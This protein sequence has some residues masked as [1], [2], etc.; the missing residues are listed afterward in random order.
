M[1]ELHVLSV[2]IIFD[3][4]KEIEGDRDFSTHSGDTSVVDAIKSHLEE[5]YNIHLTKKD[6]EEEIDSSDLDTE[7]VF[8]MSTGNGIK[9]EFY[10][11]VLNGHKMKLKQ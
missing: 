11:K 6:I 7:V 1:K 8:T 5:S 9:G 4:N 2:S 10:I 3:G